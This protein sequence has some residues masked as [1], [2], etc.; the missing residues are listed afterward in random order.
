MDRESLKKISRLA[1]IGLKDD[2]VDSLVEDLKKILAY[3]EQ[4]GEVDTEN[5]L[6][7]NHVIPEMINVMRTDEVGQ[8]LEREVFLKNAPDQ[9]GGMIRV[10]PVIKGSAYCT[11]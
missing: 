2:E 3:V 5:V 8:T 7:T 10:P 6:P 1:R 4:L 9:V 11:S